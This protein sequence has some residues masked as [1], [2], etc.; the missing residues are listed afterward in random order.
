MK[1]CIMLAI[2]KLTPKLCSKCMHKILV[3]QFEMEVGLMEITLYL[4]R[5]LIDERHYLW[6]NKLD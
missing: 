3:N 1:K 2:D 5:R 4:N 6:N